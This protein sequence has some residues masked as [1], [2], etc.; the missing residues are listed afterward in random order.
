MA[1]KETMM[2]TRNPAAPP[3]EK[4]T[5]RDLTEGTHGSIISAGSVA[6]SDVYDLAEQKIGVIE[7]IML[8]KRQGV[9]SFAVL[10]FGGFMG[11]DRKHYPLRWSMLRYNTALDGYQV[12]LDKDALEGA[13]TVEEARGITEEDARRFRGH[14]NEALDWPTV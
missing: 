8:D 13:P 7:D 3:Q 10:G 12:R 14:Y 2:D 1:T 5:S 4:P 11:L 6:G 9:V